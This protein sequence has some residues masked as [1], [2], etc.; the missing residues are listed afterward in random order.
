MQTKK[1]SWQ[2]EDKNI[3]CCFFK[4]SLNFRGHALE[5]EL[6]KVRISNFV[7]FWLQSM[8]FKIER[9]FDK[10][11]KFS[12]KIRVKMR[13]IRQ[14][15]MTINQ[16]KIS[17]RRK[18]IFIFCKNVFLYTIINR[19]MVLQIIISKFSCILKMMSRNTF[20]EPQPDSASYTKQCSG[21]P[22]GKVWPSIRFFLSHYNF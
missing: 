4:C 12:I 2:N 18:N 6:N 16:C 22:D 17:C 9:A 15:K 1:L 11:T 8:N 13:L 20:P 21:W 14:L 3:F 7:K 19:Y 5:P 10:T